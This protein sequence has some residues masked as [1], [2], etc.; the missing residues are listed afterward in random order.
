[1]REDRTGVGTLSKFGLFAEYDISS[2]FPLLTAKKMH[3]DSIVHELLWF[4]SGSTN[5]KYLNDNGVRI[6]D[7]WADD[8]GELGPIYGSQWRKWRS[9]NGPVFDQLK[10]TIDQIKTN[11]TSRRH[12]VSAWNVS[13]IHDMALP[14]CHVMFQFYVECGRLSCSLYQRSGDMFLGVPFNIA[15]YSLLTYM[16]AHVCDLR[17]WRF[18]H[19]IGDAHIYRDHLEQVEEYLAAK[20]FSLPTLKISGPKDIDALRYEHILLKDYQHGP[21]I[22]AQVAV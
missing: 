16:V 22:K 18:I 14:P 8:E 12:L 10:I 7:A 3:W 5:I 6:W 15:S 9:Y 17:P 2:E 20:T 1:M 19:T 21:T 13:D 4:I 11:P